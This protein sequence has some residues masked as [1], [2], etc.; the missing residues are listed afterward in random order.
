MTMSTDERNFRS[1]YYEKVG[2]KNVEEKKS[3]EILLKEKHLDL[4][5]LKQ[6]C[7]RFTV[8]HV[9]RSFLY[10]LLL[11]VIPAQVELHTFV[12][13]QRQQEFNDLH[14]TLQV[15]RLIDE[16]TA[17]SQVFLLMWLIQTN[18]LI[19][20][21]SLL[22]EKD[23]GVISFSAIVKCLIHFFDDDVDIYWIAK[24]FYENIAKIKS[25]VPKFVEITYAILEKE[26]PEL[27]RALQSAS[28][29]DNLPLLQWFDCCFAGIIHDNCLIKIWDKVCRGSYKILAYLVAAT[30][31]TLKH[32]K[33]KIN[34][35]VAITLA[36]K[37]LPEETSDVIVNKTVDMWLHHC[38]PL[39]G[40]DKPKGT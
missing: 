38:G 23:E 35:P 11:G 30:L 32:R 15:M 20:D 12:M 7:L 8:P 3:L 24:K 16:K 31:M 10:K 18:N 39:T 2:F 17:K 4:G 28:V 22:Y 25:E 27:Y 5:K 1:I 26:D 19:F 36:I 14:H 40:H 33:V 9:Y 21:L 13:N 34:D 6:F 29:L 37:K